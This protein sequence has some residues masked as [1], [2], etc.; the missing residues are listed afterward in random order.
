MDR[1]PEARGGALN[2]PKALPRR[3]FKGFLIP[4]VDAWT[5]AMVGSDS[6]GNAS[7]AD[8]P[9]QPGQADAQ[10][11]R[12]RHWV[13][14]TVGIWAYESD[15]QFGATEWLPGDRGAREATRLRSWRRARRSGPPVEPRL[16]AAT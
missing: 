5:A 16:L 10:R 15:G 7:S 11:G 4:R 13:S 3:L 9:A 1:D 6:V 12:R 2:P 8:N 14:V